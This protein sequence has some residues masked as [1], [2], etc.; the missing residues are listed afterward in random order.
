MPFI[1]D[2]DVTLPNG[3][4]NFVNEIDDLQKDFRVK[5]VDSFPNINAE[6]SATPD[7]LNATAGVTPG[8]AT[9]SKALVLDGSKN[10]DEIGSIGAGTVDGAIITD[11]TAILTGGALSGAALDTGVTAVTQT[12]GTNN[13]TVATTAFV[14]AGIAAIPSIPGFTI[15]GVTRDADTADR[16]AGSSYTQVTKSYSIPSNSA[17]SSLLIIIASDFDI[18]EVSNTVTGA[19]VPRY[20]SGTTNIYG[21][22]TRVVFTMNSGDGRISAHPTFLMNLAA[23]Q[24]SGSNWSVHLAASVTA[25]QT[26]TN[27]GSSLLAVEYDAI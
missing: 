22:A 18:V 17:T 15:L 10:I 11:G 16:S 2:I 24:K 20:V 6:V 9:A 27:T 14:E 12:P 25:G 13:T 3:N 19:V 21:A 8:I 26:F 4:V 7:E 5:V 1:T 23:S